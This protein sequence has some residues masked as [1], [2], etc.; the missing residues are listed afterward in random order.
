MEE[1]FGR[2]DI[3]RRCIY[4]L[5]LSPMVFLQGEGTLLCCGFSDC[6]NLCHQQLS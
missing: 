3:Y 4:V 6:D 1:G 2:G 5:T